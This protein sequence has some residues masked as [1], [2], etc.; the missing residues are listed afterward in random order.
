MPVLPVST[1]DMGA[2]ARGGGK[3]LSIGATS[4]FGQRRPDMLRAI[5]TCHLM[6]H[7]VFY[8]V[9]ICDTPRA[10]VF[11]SSVTLRQ[12]R[13]SIPKRTIGRR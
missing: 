5:G 1:D 6:T 8:T 7:R 3:D 9:Q 11:H 2:A 13:V 12:R 10:D 4:V